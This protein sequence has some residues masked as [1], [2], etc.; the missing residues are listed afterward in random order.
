[1]VTELPLGTL[2]FLRF[3]GNAITNM[4]QRIMI[5]TELCSGK[6][7][8]FREAYGASHHEE[9]L[10]EEIHAGIQEQA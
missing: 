10:G 9:I 7:Y 6:S 8:N 5:Y 2:R 3:K 4:G 1:M